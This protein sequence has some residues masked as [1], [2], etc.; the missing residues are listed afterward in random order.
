MKKYISIALILIFILC[1]TSC[2]LNNYEENTWFSKEALEECGVAELPK[3]EGIDYVKVN[4][5][6]IYFDT[7][8]ETMEEYAY[9][10][11]EYLKSKNLEYLG[12]RGEEKN[13]FKGLFKTFYFKHVEEFE[14]FGYHNNSGLRYAFIYSDGALDENGKVIFDMILISFLG[15]AY[16]LEYDN[17]EFDCTYKISIRHISE[18]P[19]AGK[20]ELPEDYHTEHTGEWVT[21][22]LA[23]WYKY[24]CACPSPSPDTAEPHIDENMDNFCDICE[25]NYVYPED[26]RF[27]RNRP[28]AYWL[29]STYA[30]EVQEIRKVCKDGMTFI[31]GHKYISS[32]TDSTTI[33]EM[34]ES[35]YWMPVRQVREEDTRVD[36]GGTE[37]FEFVLKDGTVKRVSIFNGE[38]YCD[39][40]GQYFK[41]QYV[42]KFN[43]EHVYTNYL[44][45]VSTVDRVMVYN[46]MTEESICAIP[47]D[48]LKFV[49]I[50]GI[51]EPVP[52]VYVQ[53]E[54]GK[55][56]FVTDD[57][58]YVSGEISG[59]YK[60]VGKTIFEL[61]EQ[62]STN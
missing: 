57:I 38:Y 4:D 44:S 23:H 50:D 27:L 20:Y 45:F 43:E 5:Q 48:E 31:G 24:T 3:L 16:S 12:T 1:L 21:N 25:Y 29:L 62:Y 22:E 11:Y 8:Y 47:I 14:E 46:N 51:P 42:P 34:F 61:I 32:T 15:G 37:V 18:T 6:D 35:F 36:D 39:D 9:R 59:S 19:L 53:T 55:L 60:L 41:L 56:Y 26:N 49:D 52:P 40:N 33:S 17:K 7:N 2:D 58:F 54:F 13:N 28:G 30:D 10:V